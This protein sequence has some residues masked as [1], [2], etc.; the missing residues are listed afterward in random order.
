M[1]RDLARKYVAG[2]LSDAKNTSV[3]AAEAGLI[4]LDDIYFE[5]VILAAGAVALENLVD[6]GQAPMIHEVRPEGHVAF[7]AQDDPAFRQ[8]TD[9]RGYQLA[10]Q[11]YKCTP[12]EAE[13]RYWD[14]KM[15]VVSLHNRRVS[16]GK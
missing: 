3:K 15:K 11:L 1:I 6:T 10:A 16:E 5:G 8:A 4:S 13:K 9:E 7:V 12:Q 14:A 2:C